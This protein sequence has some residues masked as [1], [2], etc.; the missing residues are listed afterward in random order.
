[1]WGSCVAGIAYSGEKMF[2]DDLFNDHK[3]SRGQ[4]EEPIRLFLR[5]TQ[6]KCIA[7]PYLVTRTASKK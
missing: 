1:M 4:V 5:K 2:V 3:Q 6:I 7:I